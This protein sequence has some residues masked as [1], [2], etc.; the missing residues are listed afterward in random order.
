MTFIANIL[1]CEQV[2]KKTNQLYCFSRIE[3]VEK[4]LNATIII[5]DYKCTIPFSI[6]NLEVNVKCLEG[7]YYI[8][9]LNYYVPFQYNMA[10]SLI[11]IKKGGNK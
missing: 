1:M 5:D 7:K 11:F 9:E 6:S 8:E 3:L 10:F 2:S 4:E